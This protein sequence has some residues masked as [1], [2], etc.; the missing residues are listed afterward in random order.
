VSASA[1]RTKVERMNPVPPLPNNFFSLTPRARERKR[2]SDFT[3]WLT[4][5]SDYMG[6]DQ[7]PSATNNLVARRDGG[8]AI[9]R[10]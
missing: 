9:R 4:V 2:C 7:S 8:A 6:Y 1:C 5:N 10:Q 3:G